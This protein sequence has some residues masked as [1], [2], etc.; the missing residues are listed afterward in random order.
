M[1]KEEE[2]QGFIKAIAESDDV[3]NHRVYA[4]WLTEQG[5]DEAAAFHARWTPEVP[6]AMKRIEAF[7]AT[8]V[9]EYDE[10]GD[11]SPQSKLDYDKLMVAAN[12]YLDT[13]VEHWFRSVY[14]YDSIAMDQFWKDYEIVT[15]RGLGDKEP[16]MF[17]CSC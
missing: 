16:H 14:D 4:A 3:L 13:G 15:G 1:T 5:E 9:D 8:F 17:R 6:K 7:A 2:R 12:R 10:Y 11:K